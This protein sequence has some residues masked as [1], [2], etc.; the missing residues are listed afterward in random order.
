MPSC[1]LGA[2]PPGTTFRVGAGNTGAQTT[3]TILGPDS[4]GAEETH[5]HPWTG[6]CGLLH[7]F[8]LMSWAVTLVGR[9]NATSGDRA[10]DNSLWNGD[11]VIVYRAT[12]NAV[13]RENF[14]SSL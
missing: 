14:F 1:R 8:L 7:P 2:L 3:A 9:E 6:Q 13:L 5:S 10:A 12:V 4:R 11:L